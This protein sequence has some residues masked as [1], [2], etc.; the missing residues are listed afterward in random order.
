MSAPFSPLAAWIAVH[1]TKDHILLVILVFVAV[2]LAIYIYALRDAYYTAKRIGTDYSPEIVNR[3]YTYIIALIVGG[4]IYVNLFHYTSEHLIQ[5]VY[6]PSRSMLPNVLPGDYL[7]V[8]KQ[9]NCLGCK[10]Q[11]QHGS[12]AIFV[13]PNNRTQ[14]YIK[15]II[16]L[17]HDKIDI[18][19]TS[20]TVNGLALDLEPITTFDHQ[21]LKRLLITHNSLLEKGAH[22]T[23]P[24]IWQKVLMPKIYPSPYPMAGFSSWVTIGMLPVTL[25]MSVPSRWPILSVLPNRYGFPVVK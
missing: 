8:D 17:P 15:R 9:V 22:G 24:V 2:A 6:V 11:L 25:V 1:S 10:T 12:I 18:K 19:G 14:L 21:E 16:G 5:A 3:P 4:L 7:L 20:I 13:N 23:Y